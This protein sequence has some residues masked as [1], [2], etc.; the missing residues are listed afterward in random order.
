MVCSTPFRRMV[1]SRCPRRRRTRLP[2]LVAQHGNRTAVLVTRAD[3]TPARGATPRIEKRSAVT[4][5]TL[6]RSANA[7]RRRGKSVSCARGLTRRCLRRRVGDRG[8]PGTLLGRAARRCRLPWPRRCGGSRGARR[9]DRG[10]PEHHTVEDAEERG[11]GA[12]AQRQREQ[13]DGREPARSHELSERV[14]KVGHAG[15]AAG[16]VPPMTLARPTSDERDYR[17]E[18][19]ESP[20]VLSGPATRPSHNRTPRHGPGGGSRHER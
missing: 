14:P 10:L 15:R 18:P 3:A 12:H 7:S 4:R 2:Q 8:S 19:E 6:T 5:D 20:V 16:S 17:A 9:R 1:R 13:G 11:V